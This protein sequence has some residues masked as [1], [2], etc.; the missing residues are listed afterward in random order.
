MLL[1]ATGDATLIVPPAATIA[2]EV[3]AA[4]APSAFA[5]PTTVVPAAAARVTVT[6]ATTP[7]WMDADGSLR[8]HCMPAGSLPPGDTSERFNAVEPPGAALPEERTRDDWA[9]MILPDAPSNRAILRNMGLFI[10][11]ANRPQGTCPSS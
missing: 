2:I 1:N 3:P 5:I 7:F 9:R 10:I 4:E 6:V 11:K 8:V